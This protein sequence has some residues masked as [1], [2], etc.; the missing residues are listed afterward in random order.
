LH[1]DLLLAYY[2]APTLKGLKPANLVLHETYKQQK[3]SDELDQ[4]KEVLRGK[5]IKMRHLWQCSKK[6]LTLVYHKKHLWEH[7]TK[8]EVKQFLKQKGYPIERGLDAVLDVLN[9]RIIGEN[10]F[11][12]EVG[13]FLGYPLADVI[14]FIEHQGKNCKFCGYW[15][16]YENEATMRS[17]F[18]TFTSV[19][20]HMIT[21]LQKGTRLIEI[22]QSA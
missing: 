1:I 9:A 10:V 6:T 11:P 13:I 4:L 18:D 16:V 3:A 7:I 19:R 14:G 17:L 20:E 2:C 21:E 12:H 8:P 5:Q 15:K 22:L